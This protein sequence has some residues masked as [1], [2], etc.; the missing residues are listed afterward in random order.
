NLHS[1]ETSLDTTY[2]LLEGIPPERIVITESG[3]ATAGDVR[4]MRKR[5][6]NA[7]LVGES[8]MR[9]PDPGARLRE[10]FGR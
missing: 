5:G 8:L 1:F 2:G 7:F 6:V 3:I 10:L 4:A 9:A